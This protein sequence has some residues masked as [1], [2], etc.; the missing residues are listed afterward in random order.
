[1]LTT[2]NLKVR[3]TPHARTGRRIVPSIVSE[4]PLKPVNVLEDGFMSPRS[5]PSSVEFLGR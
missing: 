2:T 4:D 5:T 1:M 3:V